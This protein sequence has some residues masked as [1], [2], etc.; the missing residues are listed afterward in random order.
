M[1]I[2]D[3]TSTAY[4]ENSYD[5]WNNELENCKIILFEIEKA[6]LAIT[7]GN[8]K[9]YT[10]DTGQGS[11]TVSRLDLPALQEQKTNLLCVINDLELKLGIRHICKRV[12]PLW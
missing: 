2:I 8:H 3:L 12:V 10:L 5:F 11:Q 6:I 7:I 9:S 4:N 1:P